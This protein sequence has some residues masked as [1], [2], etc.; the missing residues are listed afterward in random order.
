[1]PFL[2]ATSYSCCRLRSSRACPRLPAA[3]RA[4][5]RFGLQSAPRGLRQVRDRALLGRGALRLLDVAPRGLGL[6]GRRHAGRLPLR[7]DC[8]SPF[9]R[10]RR[11]VTS[12][13]EILTSRFG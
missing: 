5:A 7:T 6:L 1:M 4:L 3:A 12:A 2:R 10:Y 11:T 13:A 9:R 8:E